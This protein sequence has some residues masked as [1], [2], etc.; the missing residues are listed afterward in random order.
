MGITQEELL[1]LETLAG[2]RAGAAILDIGSSNLYSATA[3]G[4]RSFILRHRPEAAEGD[5]AAERL[6]DLCRRLAA[7][8]FY[9]E[10][11]GTSNKAFVGELFEAAGMTYHSLDIARGHATRILDLNTQ[12]IPNE[13]L[14]RFDLVVNAG[15]TEHVMNQFNAMK[16]VHDAASTGGMMVHITP[17][18]GYVDHGY[19]TY[20]PRFFFDL[21]GYNDYEMVECRFIDCGDSVGIVPVVEAYS[22][23]FPVL[24]EPTGKA[25]G[26]GT[27]NRVLTSPVVNGTIAVAMRKRW[28]RPFRAAVDTSTSVGEIEIPN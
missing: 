24:R 11:G 28:D 25:K 19:V 14:G 13:F 26:A 4:V 7:D 12:S 5:R 1:H 20:H 22:R 2:L 23:Y 15:T 9:R 8:S 6:D 16:I 17:V 21:C 18:F 27:E 10:A 3:E